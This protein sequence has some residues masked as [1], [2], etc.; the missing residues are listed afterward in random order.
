MPQTL[1]KLGCSAR[2]DRELICLLHAERAD[3]RTRPPTRYF[4]RRTTPQEKK[5]LRMG[6]GY[7]SHAVYL[8]DAAGRRLR[9]AEIH[10]FTPRRYGKRRPATT[11]PAQPVAPQTGQATPEELAAARAAPPDGSLAAPP[12]TYN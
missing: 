3:L 8:C 9:H 12:R 5:L 6:K 10:Y 2:P 7:M 1:Q 4:V 11:T